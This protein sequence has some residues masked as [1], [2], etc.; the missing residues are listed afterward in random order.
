[1]KLFFLSL[2][3]CF[4]SAYSFGQLTKKTWLVGG[5]GSL[6]SYNEVFTASNINVTAK[7]TAI[8]LSASVGYFFIDKFSGGLR[9]YFSSFKGES[10]GG[11]ITNYYRLAIGPFLRYYF[12][13]HDKPFN[14]LA[15]I[16]YQFGINKDMAGSAQKGK[17]NQLSIMGG[18]EIFFNSNVGLEILLGYAQKITSIDN[19][20]NASNSNK[21]GVQ[22]SI[23]FQ[24]HLEKD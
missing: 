8:D 5:A 21:K 13:N 19:L 9:P 18:S 10:S 1:M 14:L 6:Y 7:Y 12:L 2:S 3:I 24:F 11:G 4:L 16:S 23:G 22:V 17:F 20:P 15:D